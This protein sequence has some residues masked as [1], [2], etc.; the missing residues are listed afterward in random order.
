MAVRQVT[1]SFA[2]LTGS[3]SAAIPTSVGAEGKVELSEVVAGSAASLPRAT[4]GLKYVAAGTEVYRYG[5]R[6]HRVG[7]GS[8][9]VLPENNGGEADIDRRDGRAVGMCVFLPERRGAKPYP[10]R[11][12]RP[13]VFPAAC[14]ELG[15]L[16]ARSHQRM[17]REPQQREAIAGRLLGRIDA[18]T[19]AFLVDAVRII[20]GLSAV[21]A[22]TRYET[23]RRLNRARAYLHQVVDRPVE[24]A[25]LAGHAGV[26][27]F[28]LARSFKDCFGAPPA[29]YHRRHRLNLARAELRAGHLSCAEAAF[30]FGF[31][32]APHFSRA[33]KS[34]FGHPPSVSRD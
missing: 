33:Y 8:F 17:C 3:L 34:A 10:A 18:D 24:L 28:Q 7:A 23:M 19:E 1:S 25:E 12:D 31:G 6:T 20:D 9:L 27:R 16:L 26:S 4:L 29:A 11:L 32:D 22:S 21:K 13:L 14:S 2:R 5:G 15:R 30:Q